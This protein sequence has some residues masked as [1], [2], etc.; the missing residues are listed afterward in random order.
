MYGGI[1]ME[2]GKDPYTEFSPPKNLGVIGSLVGL[3]TFIVVAHFS[4]TSAPFFSSMVVAI[5]AMLIGLLWP[6][7][8]RWFL[9]FML[10]L[11]F[12]VHLCALLLIP[13]P[14]KISF[15]FVF[16][17]FFAVEIYALWKLIVFFMKKFEESKII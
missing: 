9:W 11:I 10:I 2:E 15:A 14:K 16:A 1:D 3:L 4:N 7:R 8:R 17:P 12:L 6:L 13:L 5:F